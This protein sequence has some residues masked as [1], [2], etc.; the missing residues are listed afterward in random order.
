MNFNKYVNGGGKF[1][2]RA[3][4]KAAKALQKVL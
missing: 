4:D 1:D 2:W 3:F